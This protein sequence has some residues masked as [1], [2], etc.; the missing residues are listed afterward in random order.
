MRIRKILI[1]LLIFISS[2]IFVGCDFTFNLDY[3]N[4][5]TVTTISTL[6]LPVNGTITFE[7]DDYFDFPIY[8]SPT[9]S[10]NNID[11]YNDILNQTKEHIRHT[12]ISVLTTIYDMRFATPFSTEKKE[13]IMGTTSGSGFVFMEK[14]N[15]YYF[16]TN[17][18]VINPNEYNARYEIM[19]YGDFEY[20]K[21]D[22]VACDEDLDLAVLKFEKNE[23]EDV[24]ILD[25]YSRLYYKNNVGELVLAI[26]NPLG[27]TNNVT[28]GLFKSMEE[29]K[30]SDFLVIYHTA[31]INEG[32][33]GGALVDVDGKLIGVN[34]WGMDTADEYSFSIPNYIVYIF[35]VNKGVID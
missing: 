16:I 34:T 19:T 4:T 20:S 3:F 8:V 18:H 14:D 2:F 5:D 23:R 7:N 1:L 32:S 30:N 26:G 11:M 31:A 25:I 6:P 35:L 17:Y 24:E 22:L 10:L 21:A 28:F 29:I 9:Y 13:Y 12:N 27:L 33:S 15:Y